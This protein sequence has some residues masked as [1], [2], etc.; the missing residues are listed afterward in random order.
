MMASCV[1]ERK[2]RR[3]REGGEERDKKTKDIQGKG[4]AK[5]GEER[6]TTFRFRHQPQ[7]NW[8]AV[9]QFTV[10]GTQAH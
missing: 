8:H 1:V 6:A 2:K 5:T 4:K 3:S 7:L 9:R 10:P